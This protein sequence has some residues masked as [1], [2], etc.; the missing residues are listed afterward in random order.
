[1]GTTNVDMPTIA[2]YE[3]RVPSN[4]ARSVR[5][6]RGVVVLVACLLAATLGNWFGASAGGAS[7]AQLDPAA[8]KY[9]QAMY[10]LSEADATT[11]IRNHVKVETELEALAAQFPDTFAGAWV[12]WQSRGEVVVLFTN[13]DDAASALV[14]LKDADV[15]TRV[16]EASV[17]TLDTIMDDINAQFELGRSDSVGSRD[18]QGEVDVRR[19]LV[20]LRVRAGSPLQTAVSALDA[21]P[22]VEV[23][24]LKPGSEAEE[25]ACSVSDCDPPLRG[26][27]QIVNADVKACSLGFVLYNPGVARYAT[28]ASHCAP[29]PWS[30]GGTP[31]GPTHW[32]QDAGSV[33][34]K[35]VKI[36][37]PGYWDATNMIRRPSNLRFRITLQINNPG[38]S[39]VGNIIC[40]V[41]QRNNGNEYCGELVAYHSSSTGNTNLGKVTGTLACPGDSGGPWFNPSSGRAYGFH[42]SSTTG[43]GNNENAWFSWVPYVESASGLDILLVE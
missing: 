1:M 18:L 31:I 5:V 4:S 3:E 23:T 29:S 2:E 38:A 13:E 40:R 36:N 32:T 9:A 35:A 14:I 27:P 37:S 7:D 16:S 20:T 21:H 34:A 19:G 24:V 15:E 33:D 28:T 39:L 25:D 41:G 10:E 6:G 42:V 8:V 26:G 22:L 12:N 30:H 43:C 17:A 11:A